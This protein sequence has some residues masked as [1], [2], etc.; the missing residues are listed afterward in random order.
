M[1]RLS[2]LAEVDLADGN[3]EPEKTVLRL[4]R[5]DSAVFSVAIAVIDAEG[6]VLWA[7][8]RSAR[9]GVPTT[10]L[11]A[12]AR[13]AGRAVV[14]YSE[15]EID[16][17]AP[18]AG[19]GALVGIVDG[20]RGRDLFG[21]ELRRSLRERGEVAL[22]AL[23]H[24]TERV[25]AAARASAK[26]PDLSLPSPGQ[27]WLRDARGA[28]W[29]V[30]EAEV[31]GTGLHLRLTLSAADVEGGLSGPFRR[32][33]GLVAGLL[34]ASIVAGLALARAGHRLERAE[35]EL[36]RSRDLAAMGKTAAAIAHEVKN[37]LNGLSVAVDLLASGR[38]DFATAATVHDR[39]R[40]RDRP[41]SQGGRRPDAVR[42]EPEPHLR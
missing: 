39:A 9:P 5:R 3:L 14:H 7:E 34:I 12:L 6:E 37:A 2:R 18:A 27:A 33:V 23:D 1:D 38:A 15:W 35:V 21:P 29:L 19:Q 17:T 22:V 8:P 28:R 40:A 4:A 25:V 20:R 11:L 24:G 31:P 32:L 10:L 26:S 42:G 36:A 16:V 13:G 41:A 30:T